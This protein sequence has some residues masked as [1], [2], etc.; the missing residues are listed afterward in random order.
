MYNT[1]GAGVGESDMRDILIYPYGA[2]RERHGMR[3]RADKGYLGGASRGRA[4]P[5][6]GSRSPA[7][8]GCSQND[9][10]EGNSALG[11]VGS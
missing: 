9:S 5:E 1:E 4:L 8:A 2:A 6:S 10:R 3:V 7:G 11:T